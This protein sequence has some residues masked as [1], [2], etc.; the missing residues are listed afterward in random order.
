MIPGIVYER[1]ADDQW[2][3][4]RM[5]S[6]GKAG[7]DRYL[8]NLYEVANPA[9]SPYRFVEYDSRVEE[10]FARALDHNDD[11]RFF[12]ELPDWFTVDTPIGT[13]NPDWAIMLRDG[14][15]LYLVQETKGS[16]LS[17]DRRPAEN[18]KIACAK[19]HFTAIDVEYGVITDLHQTLSRIGS[20]P[21]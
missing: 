14:D 2:E 21:R 7:L 4:T 19:K 1:M 12:V 13:Y 16:L 15:R 8:S 9:K 3:L 20:G 10:Q 11:V 5:R 6:E 17:E 18:D